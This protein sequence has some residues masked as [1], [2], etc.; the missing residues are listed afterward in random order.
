[1]SKYAHLEVPFIL[2]L[3]VQQLEWPSHSPDL[4]A[5]DDLW[6]VQKLNIIYRRHYNM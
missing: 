3:M 1:M 6:R 4:D 2:L 5:I